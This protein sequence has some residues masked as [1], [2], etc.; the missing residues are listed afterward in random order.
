MS[1]FSFEDND[2]L[3]DDFKSFELLNEVKLLLFLSSFISIIVLVIEDKVLLEQTP[4]FEVLSMK[5]WASCEISLKY[6]SLHLNSC[7]RTLKIF[8]SV[9][10]FFS[11]PFPNGVY[12]VSRTYVKTPKLHMSVAFV[13]GSYCST[14]GAE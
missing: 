4:F 1:Q 10:R 9:S 13:K 7:S 2:E 11:V 6:S 14:S 3:D 8:V 12:A 5:S